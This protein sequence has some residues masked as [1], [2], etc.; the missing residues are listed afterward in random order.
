MRYWRSENERMRSVLLSVSNSQRKC[1]DLN[2]ASGKPV[3]LE[4]IAF[5]EEKSSKCPPQNVHPNVA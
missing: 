5:L 1:N 2:G 3:Q 4:V